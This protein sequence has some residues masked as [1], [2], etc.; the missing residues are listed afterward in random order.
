MPHHLPASQYVVMILSMAAAILNTVIIVLSP[1]R[2]SERSDVERAKTVLH[3]GS[4]CR[5]SELITGTSACGWAVPSLR[6]RLYTTSSSASSTLYTH[7]MRFSE[8]GLTKCSLLICYLSTTIPDLRLGVAECNR[9]G[10][11]D[12]AGTCGRQGIEGIQNRISEA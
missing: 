9:T 12:D 10:V 8:G 4:I 5:R 11:I 7:A 3:R 2:I 6:P 1:G